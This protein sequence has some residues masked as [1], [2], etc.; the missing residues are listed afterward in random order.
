[1]AYKNIE[2]GETGGDEYKIL[3]R[4]LKAAAKSAPIRVAYIRQITDEFKKAS[5]EVE[6]RI[7]FTDSDIEISDI[8]YQSQIVP[9]CKFK[10]LSEQGPNDLILVNR[11]LWNQLSANYKAGA[12]AQ[13]ALTKIAL[14][15]GHPHGEKIESFVA[16]LAGEKFKDLTRLEFIKYV[17]DLDL[18][19]DISDIGS[20]GHGCSLEYD[21]KIKGREDVY[22]GASLAITAMGSPAAI[23]GLGSMCG[24]ECS[25]TWSR[26]IEANDPKMYQFLKHD[27]YLLIAGE[28]ALL[29]TYGADTIIHTRFIR[30]KKLLAE[31]SVGDTNGKR[32]KRLFRKLRKAGVDLEMDFLIDTIND[33]NYGQKAFCDGSLVDSEKERELATMSDFVKYLSK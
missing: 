20:A 15:N 23:V 26:R 33:L 10:A 27:A 13:M 12:M 30:M 17:K 28:G 1:M 2:I 25:D 19:L 31:A 3:A 16:D 5:V 22:A 9:N 32:I 21:Q 24:D 4:Q 18:L 29:L 11:G 14:K 7:V 6:S 8:R